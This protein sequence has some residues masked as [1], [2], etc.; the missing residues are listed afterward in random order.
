MFMARRPAYF[1][2]PAKD[3]GAIAGIGGVLGVTGSDGGPQGS[4]SHK[5]AG[6]LG[7]DQGRAKGMKIMVNLGSAFSTMLL[8]TRTWKERRKLG[9]IFRCRA[10][11]MSTLQIYRTLNFVV[12]EADLRQLP[13]ELHAI[14]SQLDELEW[15]EDREFV[16]KMV[17]A[18]IANMVAV[19]MVA[20][21]CE[22][23]AHARADGRPFWDDKFMAFC[24]RPVPPFSSP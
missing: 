21:L 20:F 19:S 4:V 22:E 9:L 16:K 23:R 18:D 2:N 3:I 10:F 6:A 11:S 7:R 17:N 5:L 12:Y 15:D 13:P 14:A 1:R 8:S 24:A